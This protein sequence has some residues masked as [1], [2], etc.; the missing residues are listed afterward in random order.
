MARTHRQGGFTI[1]EMMIA[2]TIFT[3]VAVALLQHLTISYSSTRQQRHRVF[4]YMKAQ[5][6]LSEMH[7]VVDSSETTAAIDL[8][9]YDDGAISNPVLSIATEGGN[10]LPPDHPLSGNTMITSGWEWSRRIKVRPFA[11]LNNRSVRYVT[12]T[13]FHREGGGAE[14]EVASLSSVINSVSSGY[15]TTQVYDVYLLAIENIPGWWVFMENIVP[16]VE[17]AI[18]DL[19]SR[20]PG[21]ALRTHWITKAS[22]GRSQQYKPYVNNANDSHQIVPYVYY[23]PGKMPS[24]NSSNYYYVPSM[25]KARMNEDGT[26]VH[27]YDADTNP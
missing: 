5:A 19:E 4:A 7:A 13:I 11:G 15:P 24:G 26:T 6:I 2:V 20:N 8:D 9:V 22:Y 16:S 17:S 23:Y 21:L 12:V 1:V 27:G 25:M 10:P 18:T 14:T 3:T